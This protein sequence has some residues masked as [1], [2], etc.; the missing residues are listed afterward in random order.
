MIDLNIDK[1]IEEILEKSKEE[2]TFIEIKAGTKF[3]INKK[4]ILLKEKT[5][6]PVFVDEVIDDIKKEEEFKGFKNKNIIEGMLF[7]IGVDP[8]FKFKKKYIEMLKE[9]GINPE[10]YLIKVIND[11]DT[12]VNYKIVYS[13]A[14]LNIGKTDDKKYFI[15][16]NVLEM[17][18]TELFNK[19]KIKLAEDFMEKAVDYYNKALDENSEFSL[20]YYKLGYYYRQNNQ[21][22]NAKAY[23]DKFIEYDDNDVRKQEIRDQLEELDYY[24]QFEEGYQL[25]LKGYVDKGLD[26]LIPLLD[27][28]QNWWKLFF[29]IGVAFRQKQEYEIAKPYFKNVLEINPSQVEAVNE[30]A[31]CELSTGN[32]EDAKKYLDEGIKGNPKSTELY[33]NRAAANIYLK[34]FGNAEKDVEKALNIEPDNEVA[35]MLREEID[36]LK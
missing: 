20:S 3:K 4:D 19:E 31:V 11:E 26:L 16:G 23:W 12:K 25:V 5:S 32:Y 1:K 6:F 17:K 9:S 33:T 34:D 15:Y 35:I 7:I 36:R 21:Y 27:V 10:A 24:I 28:F 2:L 14:L 13:N 18:G 8:N 30:L 29:I 22:L